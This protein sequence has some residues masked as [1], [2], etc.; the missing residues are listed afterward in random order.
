MDDESNVIQPIQ[1][2]TLQIILE[3]LERTERNHRR[4]RLGLIMVVVF[5]V[6]IITVV[7]VLVRSRSSLFT[8]SSTIDAHNLIVRDEAGNIRA[9]LKGSKNGAELALYGGP[10]G[11]TDTS[12]P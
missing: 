11:K 2:Q 9:E 10:S 12:D 4:L 8:G 7:F 1:S 5:S 3:R 6:A